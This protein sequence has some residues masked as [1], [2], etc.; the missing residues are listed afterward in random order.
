MSG[1]KG[2]SG[3]ANRNQGRKK[4]ECQTCQFWTVDTPE[5][6][7]AAQDTPGAWGMC[8]RLKVQTEADFYC[9]KYIRQHPR[10]RR[11]NEEMMD[12]ETAIF[13][14]ENAG[15]VI[16]NPDEIIV[17]EIRDDVIFMHQDGNGEWIVTKTGSVTFFDTSDK[18]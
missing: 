7:K 8:S 15:W 5:Q 1:V 13:I 12:K 14:L 17:D 10:L 2:R 4:N 16:G 9:K 11:G 18:E 6:A 3:G